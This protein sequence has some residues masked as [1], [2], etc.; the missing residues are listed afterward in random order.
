MFFNN[1]NVCW[2][3]NGRKRNVVKKVTGNDISVVEPV[4][5]GKGGG[6]VII[7]IIGIVIYILLKFF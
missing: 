3:K 1:R 7:V 6:I 5:L 4:K 2:N